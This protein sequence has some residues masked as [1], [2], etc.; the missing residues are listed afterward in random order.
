MLV[1]VCWYVLVFAAVHVDFDGGAD[2]SNDDDAVWLLVW[3]P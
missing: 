3:L 2:D 1:D